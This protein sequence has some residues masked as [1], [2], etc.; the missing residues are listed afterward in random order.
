MTK[1]TRKKG[2]PNPGCEKNQ[3]H[4]KYNA[5]DVYCTLCSE[6]LVY[7][8]KSKKCFKRIEDTDIN[9]KYCAIC[10]A[11]WEDR[12]KKEKDQAKKI[13]AGAGAFLL[14]VGGVVYR[15]IKKR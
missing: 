13:A 5:D 10:E 7:V 8:C 9:H 11:K 4:F 1:D 3:N 12:K 2:C 15:V 14:T 6:K